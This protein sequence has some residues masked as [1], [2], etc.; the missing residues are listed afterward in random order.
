M[1]LHMKLIATQLQ[2]CFGFFPPPLVLTGIFF[3][4]QT[5]QL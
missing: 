5:Q 3:T 4:L 1:L 2:Q